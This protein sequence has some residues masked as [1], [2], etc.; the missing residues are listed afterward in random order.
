MLRQ[1]GDHRHLQRALRALG[2]RRHRLLSV[3][4]RDDRHRLRWPGSRCSC[5]R[6]AGSAGSC[7]KVPAWHAR[8]SSRRSATTGRRRGRRGRVC[9]SQA[10]STYVG[11]QWWA[12]WY[13]G[14]EPGGGGYVAQ[15]MMSAQGRAAFA[16]RHAVVHRRALLRAAV[17][18]D[19]RRPRRRSC[20]TP[21]ITDKE[22]G[23]V[24]VMR[25]HLPPGWRG[26]L[27][28]AFFA[29]YM[30]TIS[31]QLNWGT[32]YIVNDFY[33]RFVQAR[34]R[35]SGT[36]CGSR[37]STTLVLMVLS[38]DRHVLSREHPPGVG[39]R[40]RVRRG[41]RPGADPAVVLVAHQRL[42]GDRRDGWR[43]GRLRRTQA[44]HHA[45]VSL[46]AARRRGV[47]HRVLARGDAADGAGAREHISSRSIAARVRTVPAGRGSPRW[48]AVPRPG[49]S[50]DCSSTGC[51]RRSSSTQCSSALAACSSGHDR[52]ARL[53]RDAAAA[54][55]VIYTRLVPSRLGDITS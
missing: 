4:L 8:S 32:S 7:A 37:A 5:P 20:S 44:V 43:G 48:P 2:R 13:P 38:G 3:H 28:G 6:S 22:A 49:A 12:S 52:R 18:V 29:A 26:L 39:V 10:S 17:A 14:Q 50:A 55:V 25:D 46:H 15:R 34:R 40:A 23:Y 16:A 11:V 1:P 35:A 51:R 42:V 36:T 27:L 54:V 21:T 24:M 30:S 45:R 9:R 53:L 33:R 47:D 19:P 41:H 31:T